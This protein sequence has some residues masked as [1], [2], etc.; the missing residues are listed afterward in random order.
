MLDVEDGGSLSQQ[1]R[2]DCASVVCDQEQCPARAKQ[3]T[4]LPAERHGIMQMLNGLEARDQAEARGLARVGCERTVANQRAHPV[5]RRCDW[6][7]GWLN[8]ANV[9]EIAPL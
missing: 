2:A 5:V 1:A 4:G 3:V 9:G 6:C 7:C 8:A